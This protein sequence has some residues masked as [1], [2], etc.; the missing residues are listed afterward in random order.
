MRFAL[1][2]LLLLMV[3]GAYAQ[4]KSYPAGYFRYPLAI[5]PKLNANFG[6]MRPNHFHMGLD[7]FTERRENLPIYAAADGYVARLKIEPG[8]FGRAIY[9]NHPNGFTTLYAHMNDFMPEL[10]AYLKKKQYEAESWRTELTLPANLFPVK[11]GQFIGYSGNTGGS[12]GPHVHF[13]IR[14]TVSEKCLN[15]LLFGFNIPDQVTPDLKNLAIYDRNQSIYEQAPRIVPLAKKSNVYAPSSVIKL[16]TDKIS[17]AIHATDRMTGVPN[18]NGI[19]KV[20]VFEGSK[21]I[22][23]F[24]IDRI[25]YD[26]TRYL[27]AHIDHKT[28]ASGGAYLQFLFPLEGD[29]LDI[30]QP[31]PR[32]T[33]I[34][35]N[36]TLVHTLRI[37]VSDPYGNTSVSMI[38]IQ[39]TGW[40]KPVFPATGVLMKA[41]E[42]NVFE[43]D[44]IQLVIPENGLYD[45]VYFRYAALPA[46]LPQSYSQ[47]FYLHEPK[48][49]VHSYFTVRIKADKQVP[50]PLRDK[51][52]IVRTEKN[53]SNV[54]KA[55]WEL[56][57]YTSAFRDFGDFTLVADNEPPTITLPGVAN[58]ANL[59]RATRI[60]ATVNDNYLSVKNFRAE[61]DGKWLMF[62]QKGR[63][64]T[65]KFD[66]NCGPG[67][68]IL[69]IMVDDEAGNRTTKEWRFS[70]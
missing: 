20:A 12:Q 10:E 30:Y 24:R 3:S 7:L 1:Y 58:G 48:I 66:E 4:Q 32:S 49:P 22:G 27:N 54:A 6:E 43:N 60:V 62:S 9:L 5:A 39:R 23:G 67:E 65:Y 15:P 45:S 14:E 2:S 55:N 64:F 59:S 8:G 11:K 69:K 25:G 63:T 19:F 31:N 26:E 47:S 70:R 18:A 68:H 34:S 38:Q 56:G 42:L 36:D 17:I 21:Q 57:W 41:N 50:Y 35:L 53:E 61:L 16:S 40:I 37:E 33:F 28:R 52:I 13:E 51:M 29:Q 44:N 46:L